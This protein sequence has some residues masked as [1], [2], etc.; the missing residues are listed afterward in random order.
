MVLITNAITITKIGNLQYGTVTNINNSQRA[1]KNM[2]LY[3]LQK[4]L[5]LYVRHNILL[6]IRNKIHFLKT[7]HPMTT[8]PLKQKFTSNLRFS[9]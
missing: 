4:I 7:A 6:R 1:K 5:I 9:I 8:K 2:V 3:E